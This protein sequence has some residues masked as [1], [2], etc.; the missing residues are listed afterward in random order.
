M[1]MINNNISN[2]IDIEIIKKFILAFLENDYDFPFNDNEQAR[3]KEIYE[4]IK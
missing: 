4:V 2:E 3:L 1:I